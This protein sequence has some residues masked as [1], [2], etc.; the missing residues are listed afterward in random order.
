MGEVKLVLKA[1]NSD[2]IR[3]MKEAQ[4][5]TQKVYDTSEKGGK[6]EKGILQEIDETLVRLNKSKQKAFS[7]EEI[8]KYN[9]KI[10]E[11]KQHLQE[12]EQAGIKV[13][14]SGNSMM[15]SVG[16]WALGF[17]TVTAAV[18]AFKEIIEST[19]TLS[20]KF[21]ATLNGWKE[22]FAAMARAIANNDFEN[23]FKNVKAAV[24]EG[25]RF[26]EME[27]QIGDAARAMKIRIGE[28]ET[29]LKKLRE[30][31]NDASKSNK[32]RL[33]AG[34]EAEQKVKENAKDR[35]ELANMIYVNDIKRAEFISKQDEATI[36]RLLK[37]EPM[38]MQQVEIGN[39]Y[40]Q[41]IKDRDT[42]LQVTGGGF[43]NPADD[44]EV[45]IITAKIDAL[46]KE[47]VAYGKLAIGLGSIIDPLKDKIVLDL[48]E[49]EIAKQSEIN[50]RV[51]S[52]VDAM[53]AK[54]KVKTKEQIEDNKK[55]W[56]DYDK[57]FLDNLEKQGKEK[58]KAKQEQWDKE[59]EMAKMAKKQLEDEA[60]IIFD[61]WTNFNEELA[62][63]NEEARQ[64]NIELMISTTFALLSFANNMSAMNVEQASE[65]RAI[66]DQQVADS[67][68]AVA[69]E[70]KIGGKEVAAKQA[71]LAILETAQRDALISEQNARAQAKE[72]AI[73]SVLTEKAIAIAEVI[74]AT[75]VAN[76]KAVAMFPLTGGLPFTAINTSMMVKSII[77][78]GIAAALET[79]TTAK[80]KFAKGGWTGN[81]GGRDETGERVAGTVHEKEFV[82]RKGPANKFRDVL[83]AINRD[84]KRMIF[85]SFNKLNPDLFGG[86][87]NNIIVDNKG[88]NNRLDQLIVENKKLNAKLT[89]ESIQ[90][91][92]DVQ[93]IRKGN[94][95]R[96]IRK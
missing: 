30:V 73:A 60:K 88:S 31:Q 35:L 59:V 94:S 85:N 51:S 46:G 53:I 14:K 33:E 55:F 10:E 41:L 11:A 47:A 42:L 36:I 16:K 92:G 75:Q 83:E 18:K 80:S 2:H 12:Y 3:K 57:W 43:L 70:I 1:D 7:Y 26:A 8:A 78:I 96:T 39:K 67:Q 29:A 66:L 61:Y 5:A 93:V 77:A 65:K 63:I 69:E 22:G 48:E 15:Q 32:E 40:N 68:K 9:K 90:N 6:R 64:K 45:K 20:D 89:S 62:N 24:T 21:K 74:I 79:I 84:D 25:Q 54:D 76:A 81:G 95:I 86:T 91:F 4:T 44:P 72:M 87:V 50:L 38:L 19:D 17:V 82:I 28:N 71:Q 49:I 23:F 34:L 13:E 56:E 37:M 58:D 52:R 27:N